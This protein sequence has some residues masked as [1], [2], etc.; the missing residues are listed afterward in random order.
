M[1]RF[2]KDYCGVLNIFVPLPHRKNYYP[3]NMSIMKIKS[4]FIALAAAAAFAFAS[5]GTKEADK[6]AEPSAISVDSDRKSVV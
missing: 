3:Y 2:G 1:L 4:I 6:A 5:C